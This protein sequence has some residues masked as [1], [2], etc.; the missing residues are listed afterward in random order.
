MFK[1][2]LFVALLFVAGYLA[3]VERAHTCDDEKWTTLLHNGIEYYCGS[4]PT[5]CAPCVYCC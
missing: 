5:N 4:V 1:K 3:S 2:M